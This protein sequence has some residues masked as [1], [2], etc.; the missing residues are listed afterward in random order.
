MWVINCKEIIT[1]VWCLLLGKIEMNIWGYVQIARHIQPE[2]DTKD[3]VK[4]INS[5]R[6]NIK[7]MNLLTSSMCKVEWHGSLLNALDIIDAREF[8]KAMA[9]CCEPKLMLLRAKANGNKGHIE[10]NIYRLSI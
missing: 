6:Q 8:D 4:I 9:C 2:Y 10:N 5:W 7:V 3:S 1:R